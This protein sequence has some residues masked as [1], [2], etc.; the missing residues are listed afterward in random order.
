MLLH[1][2][3]FHR[4]KPEET[5]YVGDMDVDFLAGTRAGVDTF[6]LSTGSTPYEDLKKIKAIKILGNLIDLKKYIKDNLKQ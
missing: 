6:L 3:D 5:F 1:I 4:V 2:M